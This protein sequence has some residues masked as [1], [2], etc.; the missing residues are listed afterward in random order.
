ML[1]SYMI[2]LVATYVS[3][4]DATSAVSFRIPAPDS[5]F[6]DF[7]VWE[8]DSSYNERRELYLGE[9]FCLVFDLREFSGRLYVEIRDGG[10]LL[11]RAP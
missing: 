9:S 1:Y 6:G 8:I 2:E 10:S 4:F 7:P 3:A 5:S 11:L